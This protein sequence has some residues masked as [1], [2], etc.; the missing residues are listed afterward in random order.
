MSPSD[1]VR[2][3]I[4]GGGVAGLEAALALRALAGDRVDLTLV[5]ARDD[6][7][8]RPMLVARPFSKGKVPTV[9]LTT[10]A[11]DVGAD[12]VRSPVSEI[13][14]AAREVVSE[15][16]RIPYDALVVA[17][18]AR[19]VPAFPRA[20]TFTA[21]P[22]PD[23]L[24]G[25]LRD[26]EERYSHRVA[27]VAPPGVGWTIPVYELA[28]LT[29]AEVEGM[30]VDDADIRVVTAEP[31]PLSIFGT[32]ASETVERLLHAAGITLHAGAQATQR[33]DGAL[34]LG[35]EVLKG[36]RVVA[37]PRLEGPAFP[38]LPADADGFIPVDEYGRVQGLEGV[39]AAGDG[40]DW[41][42]KQGGLATQQA[43]VIA[44][45]IARDAGADVQV[46]PYR[47]V[48][49]GQLLTDRGTQQLRSTA[50]GVGRA[51][52]RLMWWPPSKVAGK[53]LAPYLEGET[54][55]TLTDLPPFDDRV[56][57]DVDVA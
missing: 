27:F 49:R 33:D 23:A 14:T 43:D 40:A 34:V 24:N 21:E 48:L 10:I 18:G 4:V 8:L 38:G 41:E 35:D 57:V 53:Y 36:Y 39:Y 46:E 19:P 52:D 45:V 25:L 5:S 2:V 6:F 31:R 37:I 44:A 54:G 56:A 26:L 9:P 12:L 50:G 32:A 7:V 3:V 16:E 17:V 28:L 30:G 11:R 20:L 51:T 1:P 55:E 22:D 42:I 47:P 15:Q 29:A 13:D